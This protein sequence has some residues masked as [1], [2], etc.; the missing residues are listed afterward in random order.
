MITTLQGQKLDRVEQ[1]AASAQY[2]VGILGN[3]ETGEFE[4]HRN[5]EISSVGIDNATS[6]GM[7]FMGVFGLIDGA[8]HTAFEVALDR[9]TMDHLAQAILLDIE[10]VFRERLEQK[11]LDAWL[12]RLSEDAEGRA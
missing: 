11:A 4:L 12:T 3:P 8:A 1:I 7:V 9:K 10:T 6:R 2:C 5:G